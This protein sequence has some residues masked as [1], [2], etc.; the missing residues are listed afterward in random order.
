MLEEKTTQN[1]QELTDEEVQNKLSEIIERGG[2]CGDKE[3]YLFYGMML[4]KTVKDILYPN[5]VRDKKI[6]LLDSGYCDSPEYTHPLE[7]ILKI[8]GAEV[9]KFERDFNEAELIKEYF[10]RN[11]VLDMKRRESINQSD[12]LFC[13]AER[14]CNVVFFPIIHE[15]VKEGKS[16]IL[17]LNNQ[18]INKECAKD[19]ELAS[20]RELKSQGKDIHIISIDY[21]GKMKKFL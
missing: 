19:Y 6:T 16:T 20:L 10:R 14:V 1:Q 18:S 9:T 7:D 17:F 3:N 11:D 5:R 21:Y 2:S 12:Y 4:N 8:A 13:K 15:A